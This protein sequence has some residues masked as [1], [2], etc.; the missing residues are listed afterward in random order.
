M[1][2][3]YCCWQLFFN[4]CASTGAPAETDSADI[5]GISARGAI[6]GVESA[7]SGPMYT[8]TGGRNIRLA[9][10]VPEIQ[11]VVPDY[12]PIYIQGLLIN[13]IG[14]FSAI[15]LIDRQNLNKIIAEQN[16]AASGRFSDRDFVSIGNL[17][18]A[19]AIT[20]DPSQI[21]AAGRCWI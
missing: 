6:G 15:S 1:Q 21:E 4:A 16:L 2:F 19:Q 12:L 11:G 17:A 18:N 14:K 8:G 5:S 3:L 9:V 10:L 20:F 7:A 13:N